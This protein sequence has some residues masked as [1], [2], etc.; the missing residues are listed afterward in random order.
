MICGVMP[1]TTNSI[2]INSFCNLY[3]CAGQFNQKPCC[4]IFVVA[5]ILTGRTMQGDCNGKSMLWRYL[6]ACT[7]LAGIK[8]RAWIDGVDTSPSKHGSQK[9]GFFTHYPLLIAFDAC[10]YIATMAPAA[11]TNSATFLSNLSKPSGNQF[12]FVLLVQLRPLHRMYGLTGGFLKLNK[13]GACRIW[14]ASPVLWWACWFK[15][16]PQSS[17]PSLGS[18]WYE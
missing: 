12:M 3:Q 9:R 1:D 6:S 11:T 18:H 7:N 17:V 5:T 10:T 4:S 2:F 16:K 14:I 8:N 15:S 13:L